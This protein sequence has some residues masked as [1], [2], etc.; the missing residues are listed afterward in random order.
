MAAQRFP[1]TRA[2]RAVVLIIAEDAM[3]RQVYGELFALRGWHVKTAAGAREG[4]RL[5]R[6]RRVGVV[7]LSL[8]TGAARLRDKLRAL[9][10]LLRV[11]ATGMTPLPFDLMT[12]S[13]RQ[14]LH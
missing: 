11:H 7:V 13:A 12:P 14:Q 3:A 8:P 4:L 6:D 1:R 9:R 2:A 10:P 5:A